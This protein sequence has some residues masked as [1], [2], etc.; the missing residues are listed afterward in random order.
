MCDPCL[1]YSKDRA[2][3]AL[4]Y[5]DDL[6]IKSSDLDTFNKFANRIKEKFPVGS[7]G[8]AS[9]YLGQRIVQNPDCI[10]MDQET[11]IQSLLSKYNMSECNEAESPM[12]SKRLEEAEETTTKPYRSLVG[13]LMYLSTH[14]RPDIAYATGELSKFNE[15]HGKEHWTA[16]KR[17]LRYL[18]HT[19]GYCIEFKKQNKTNAI[20]GYCD[21][22]WAGNWK[23][24]NAQA[25]KSTMGFI[26]LKGGGL[27][28]SMSKRQ[29]TIALSTAEA[30]YIA[31]AAAGQEA[32]HLRQLDLDITG[33]SP[34]II[35]YCD[36]SAAIQLTKNEM[37]QSRAKHIAIRYHFIRE[38]YKEGWLEIKH[39]KGE[40]NLADMMTKPLGPNKITGLCK[41]IF[42]RNE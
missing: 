34:S 12:T 32:T 41:E 31:L 36:N 42:K 2:I 7:I 40:Y 28:S 26:F 21:S 38:I 25:A 15:R 37:F 18:K 30:E 23:D 27:V 11:M 13:S 9:L 4:L 3:I 22:D 8:P 19:Q 24:Q 5:V 1:L 33:V 16:A 20:I 17:V 6:L 39:I 14:N 35:L 29:T 10:R